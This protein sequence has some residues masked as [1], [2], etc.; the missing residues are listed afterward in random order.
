MRKALLGRMDDG[1]WSSYNNLLLDKATVAARPIQIDDPRL[2]RAY[3]VSEKPTE[4]RL[5]RDF[6]IRRLASRHDEGVVHVVQSPHRECCA[7]A[8]CE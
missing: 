1:W 5:K 6:L 2:P 7:A 3:L 4:C 8:Y